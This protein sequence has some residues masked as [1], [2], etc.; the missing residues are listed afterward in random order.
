MALLLQ[1]RADVLAEL[2]TSFLQQFKNYR[3]LAHHI[4]RASCHAAALS[5]HFKDEGWRDCVQLLDDAVAER[6]RQCALTS[7]DSPPLL[8]AGEACG[9]GSGGSGSGGMGGADEKP[10]SRFKGRR[11]KPRAAG[12][13]RELCE[14]AE[15]ARARRDETRHT[16]GG[17]P[18]LTEGAPS[19]GSAA[20]AK[21]ETKA[22]AKAAAAATAAEA[23]AASAPAAAA[24]ADADTEVDSGTERG[25]GSD[26]EVDSEPEAGE[27]GGDAGGAEE[28]RGD[29]GE[30]EEQGVGA[31]V[32][33]R[34][35]LPCGS[36]VWVSA[37]L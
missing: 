8:T 2:P 34:G 3:L 18:S 37:C 15:P 23:A 29:R 25:T 16:A 30:E 28:P 31:D 12:G 26:T 7:K 35:E 27:A 21:T 32:D 14:E 1:R 36:G 13:G 10:P 11:S 33:R 6:R 9:G 24:A 17:G 4:R 20:K 19:A 22:A 5:T